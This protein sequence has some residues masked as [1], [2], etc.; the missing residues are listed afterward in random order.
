VIDLRFAPGLPP[1]WCGRRQAAR[2]ANHLHFLAAGHSVCVVVGE[3]FPCNLHPSGWGRASALTCRLISLVGVK[4][5][6]LRI[7]K[8]AVPPYFEC[9]HCGRAGSKGLSLCMCQLVKVSF[10]AC[11]SS[12]SSFS[13]CRCQSAKVSLSACAARVTVCTHPQPRTT[14]RHKVYEP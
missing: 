5:S 12:P 10:S 11:A 8:Q 4:W 14:V 13:L 6:C 9:I 7:N 1:G 3:T 2:G